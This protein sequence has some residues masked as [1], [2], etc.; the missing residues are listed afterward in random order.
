MEHPF[1]QHMELKDHQTH[2][3]SG[4]QMPSSSQLVG[5]FLG[6]TP[7]VKPIIG[8]TMAIGEE[9]GSFNTW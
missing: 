7:F 3:V 5:A 6:P 1:T 8:S 2:A 9:G 4:G